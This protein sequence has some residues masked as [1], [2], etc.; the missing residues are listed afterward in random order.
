MLAFRKNVR[1]G[2]IMNETETAED[3]LEIGTIV[4]SD[5]WVLR[6][7]TRLTKAQIIVGNMRYHRTGRLKYRLVGDSDWS[8]NRIR[9]AT[10]DDIAT[11]KKIKKLL[12]E[13]GERNEMISELRKGLK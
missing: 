3:N 5:G 12:A 4:I 9:L 13:I 10:D 7:I 11:I 6:K 1:K 8:C 2:K